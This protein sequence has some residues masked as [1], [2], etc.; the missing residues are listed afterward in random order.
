MVLAARIASAFKIARQKLRDDLLLMPIDDGYEGAGRAVVRRDFL[1]LI[2][3]DMRRA[4]GSVL[5]A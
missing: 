4:H 5:Y 2:R 1:S 3:L